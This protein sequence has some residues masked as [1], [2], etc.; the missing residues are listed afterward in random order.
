MRRT[1]HVVTTIIVAQ[2]VA[3]RNGRRIQSDGSDEPADDE[4][5]EDRAGEVAA[6]LP[7]FD[8]VH[9]RGRRSPE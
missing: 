9:C 8:R 1:G 3:A 4:D 5:R 7:A 6:V 2:M